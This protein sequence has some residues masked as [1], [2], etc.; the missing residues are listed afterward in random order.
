[1]I[2][3]LCIGVTNQHAQC[4][5]KP[6]NQLMIYFGQI[7]MLLKNA[8]IIFIFHNT[9]ALTTDY[10]VK[11]KAISSPRSILCDFKVDELIMVVCPAAISDPKKK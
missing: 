6:I 4:T 10:Y 7:N 11:I 2:R 3:I 9:I 8:L 5:N 1:M